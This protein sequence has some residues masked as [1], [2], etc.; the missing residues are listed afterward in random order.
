MQQDIRL[1]AASET[2]LVG[3]DVQ[4]LDGSIGRIDEA[5]NAADFIVV[6]TGRWILAKSKRVMLPME[7]VRSADHEEKKIFVD[8]TK[9]EIK[10]APEF[11][12]SLTG[13][14]STRLGAHYGP[15]G[16]GFRQW[17]GRQ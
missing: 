4:A 10:R 9:T 3:Y 6:D 14:Y 17:N 12:D 5:P 15:G 2:D 16:A 13:D 1:A 7:V 11:N 8:R